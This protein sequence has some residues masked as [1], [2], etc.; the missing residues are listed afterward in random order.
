MKREWYIRHERK[1]SVSSHQ[2]DQCNRAFRIFAATLSL[3]QLRAFLHIVQYQALQLVR[4][5]KLILAT[6]TAQ[7]FVHVQ[8][9]ERQVRQ[10]ESRTPRPRPLALRPAAAHLAP[11]A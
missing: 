4:N 11:P 5:L 2:E 1:E 7:P 3:P 6:T 8:L 10:E 9:L